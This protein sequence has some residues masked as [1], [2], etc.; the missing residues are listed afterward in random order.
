MLLELSIINFALI[1]SLKIQFS[2]GLNILTGETGAGKSIIIDALGLVLGQRANKENIRQGCE[3]TIVEALFHIS[4]ENKFHVKN[5]LEDQGIEMDDDTVII[6]REVSIS[7]KNICRVNGRLVTLQLIKKLSELLIDIHGQ[8]E[9][10]SLLHW[11]THKEL[12]DAYGIDQ[13]RDGLKNT[14]EFYQKYLQYKKTLDELIR[15]EMQLEREKE[16][17]KFQLKEIDQ[18]K[19][20][21]P[22][23]EVELEKRR[24]ILANSEKL[25][26]SAN[27]AYELIYNRRENLESIY[28]L[29]S[30]ALQHIENLASIDASMEGVLEQINSSLIQIEDAGFVLRDYSEGIEFNPDELN[31]IEKRLNAIHN[32]KRKYGESIEEILNYKDRIQS[33]LKK[34]ENRNEEEERLRLAMDGS[35]DAYMR[36]AEKLSKA[37][38]N[39]SKGLEKNII[40]ELKSL[41]MGKVQ[42][43]VDIQTSK[44]YADSSGLDRIE[45]LISPNIGQELKPLTKIASGG[46]IAR[47]MLA[48]KS[49]LAEVDNIDSL[50]FDE[51][52]TG[53]SGRIAQV[54]AEKMA[55]LS[56][57]YQVIC[58]TH[59]P[60]IASMADTHFLIIKQIKN[61]QTFTKIETLS[62]D[63][64]I[65]ELAR[66]LGG[67]SLT[68]LTI[69]HAEEFLEMASNI[70]NKIKK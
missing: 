36:E 35:W 10:Q 68:E 59:L 62:K 3:K 18:A 26:H 57:R 5:L 19:L 54:V 20:E 7:G 33:K 30:K 37:R 24:N 21:D 52:D 60:Q 58:V 69:N 56:Q 38:K 44:K 46:E 64:R 28:D 42:F 51:I 40:S 45:F 70:K 11:E 67:A 50:I 65:K 6:S 12:L 48:L 39:I 16:I 17:I 43:K 66:M 55:V 29:L 63:D 8:H 32:L 41:G 2:N 31:H 4:S 9:H 47:I 25:F 53:I 14:N 61:N 27:A 23:E 13:L 22:N 1:E 49:I 15:D 34:I